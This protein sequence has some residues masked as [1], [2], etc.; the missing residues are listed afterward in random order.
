MR[1]MPRTNVPVAIPIHADVA[2]AVVLT[3]VS[4]AVDDVCF[5][6]VSTC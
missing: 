4:L 3:A 1:I 5:G 6:A 2:K